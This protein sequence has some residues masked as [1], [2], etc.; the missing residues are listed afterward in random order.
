MVVPQFYHTHTHISWSSAK[1]CTH[2]TAKTTH[3]VHVNGAALHLLCN[4]MW[5]RWG[6]TGF[7]GLKQAENG[8]HIAPQLPVDHPLKSDLPLLLFI[9]ETRAVAKVNNPNIYS[10]CC[11]LVASGNVSHF[12]C[13]S[14]ILLN[15]KLRS[16]GSCTWLYRVKYVCCG[17]HELQLQL[18]LH[19]YLPIDNNYRISYILYA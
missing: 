17:S 7:S 14:I 13:F 12:L 1:G 11:W 18:Q 10:Y 5:L 3:P 4:S 19:C 6:G 2:A 15:I 16:K 9:W 8:W